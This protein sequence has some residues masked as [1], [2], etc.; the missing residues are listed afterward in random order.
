MKINN[1]YR[2]VALLLAVV[3]LALT[4]ACGSETQ[5]PQDPAK[6][7]VTGPGEIGEIY[8]YGEYHANER[9]LQKE[10]ELWRDCYTRGMRYL[11]VEQAYYTAQY[12]NLWMQAEDD[13]IL[14]E[15]FKDWE[16]SLSY[17]ELVLD[18]YRSIKADCPETIF[19]GTDIGHQY[20]TTGAR[21]EAYLRAEGQLTSEEYKRAD[22]CVIQGRSFYLESD[23]DKQDIYRE[24]AMVQNFIAAVERL[25]AGTDI[26][27]IYGAAHTDPTALSWGGTVDSMAKQLAAYYGDKLHCTDLTQLPAPTVTEESFTIAGKSYTATWLGGEDMSEWS[28]QYQSRTFWRLE[29]AYED[30]ADAALIDD[31]LPYNNYPVKVEVG[32]AFAV[33]L[34][35]KSD[36]GSEWM[37]YR[38]DGDEWQGMPVTV[39]FAPEEKKNKSVCCVSPF[40]CTQ[41]GDLYWRFSMKNQLYRGREDFCKQKPPSSKI[42]KVWRPHYYETTRRLWTR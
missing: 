26:M 5:Q 25:P 42:V 20:E 35:R 38:A 40:C 30:F 2:M 22:A 23:P 27:G 16:G 24:N 6:P 15:V 18:F 17:N 1:L 29:N 19:V 37:Y 32:Q 39:G 36:G 12:F 41:G 4:A 9:L 8:L 10:L 11:F 28:Q 7:A 13:T 34:I 3:L 21:Y 31:V 33:E 14:L